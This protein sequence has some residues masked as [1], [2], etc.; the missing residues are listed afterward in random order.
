MKTLGTSMRGT[1][2]KDAAGGGSDACGPD[3]VRTSA[4]KSPPAP[5]DGEHGIG[6][7]ECRATGVE[8]KPNAELSLGGG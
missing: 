3:P 5:S 1:V 8:Q 4:W 6:E 2:E 7:H